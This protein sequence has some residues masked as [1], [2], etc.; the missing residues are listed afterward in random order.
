MSNI[1]TGTHAHA[2]MCTHTVPH[3]HLQ[4]HPHPPAPVP[5]SA[6]AASAWTVHA[7]PLPC[8][9]LR[10]HEAPICMHKQKRI[11][12]PAPRS[13]QQRST[14]AGTCHA[15][16]QPYA[17]TCTHAR[18]NRARAHTFARVH[19]QANKHAQASTQASALAQ[20]PRTFPV[21][22][23]PRG[24]RCLCICGAAGG[25]CLAPQ[26][27]QRPLHL[28]RQAREWPHGLLAGRLGLRRSQRALQEQTDRYKVR[29]VEPPD[30][31]LRR[32]GMVWH[33]V[34]MHGSATCWLRLRGEPNGAC[35]GC[36][37]VCR[38]RTK[39]VRAHT[40]AHTR[41]QTHTRAH[42][43]T[44]A[45]ARTCSAGGS[46]CCSGASR[47]SGKSATCRLAS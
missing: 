22:L 8:C 46:A 3:P 31:A 45:H 41:T 4:L 36:A 29:Q 12:L 6:P 25:R 17:H 23:L 5:E 16:P 21:C 11:G 19:A 2:H 35:V 14:C 44:H 28:A 34:H 7:H 10:A 24:C 37:C 15:T 30:D 38:V 9:M 32:P 43:R 20:C 13:H 42:P 18:A 40:H 27:R 1:R 39:P 33:I 47:S 26:H